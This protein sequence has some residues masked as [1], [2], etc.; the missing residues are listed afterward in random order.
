MNQYGRGDLLIAIAW[1]GKSPNTVSAVKVAKKLG[2][3]SIGLL[4]FDGSIVKDLPDQCIMS[5]VMI[6]GTWKMH[7]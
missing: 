3:K 6:V 2:R 7:A 5:I 1:S 4:G